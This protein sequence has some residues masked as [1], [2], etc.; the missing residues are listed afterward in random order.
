VTSILSLRS[1]RYRLGIAGNQPMQAVAVFAHIGLQVVLVASSARWG[2]AK[3]DRAL[4]K[5]MIEFLECPRQ[6][7]PMSVI[8]STTTSFPREKQGW[9]QS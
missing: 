9:R 2:V 7:S 8:V 1:A 5:K 4:F 3:P 6:R